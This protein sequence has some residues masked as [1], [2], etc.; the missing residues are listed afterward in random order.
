MSRPP[1]AGGLQANPL[2][3]N[4][5]ASTKVLTIGYA[6]SIDH[7]ARLHVRIR[8]SDDRP[9]LLEILDAG[10]VTDLMPTGRH[11]GLVLEIRRQKTI[12]SRSNHPEL[13]VEFI[14]R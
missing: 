11:Y 4:G 7:R 2:L 5:N 9:H 6:G 10:Q 14:N 3:H 8:R 12:P 1:A 13:H